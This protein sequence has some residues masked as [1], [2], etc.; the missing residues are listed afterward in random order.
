MMSKHVSILFFAVLLLL[1]WI[2]PSARAVELKVAV[3]NME[4][5][6]DEYNKTKE[7]NAQFKSRA[8]EMDIKRKELLADVKARKAEL[9][10]ISAEARDKSLS[11][12]ERAKK[13]TQ[14]EEKYAQGRE[15]EEKLVEFD[16]ACKLQFGE[17]MRQIQ[18]Q[19]VV[20]IRAIIQAY[21]KDR[22]FTLVLDSSGKTMNN[23][24]SVLTCDPSFDI[25]DA[26]L[27]VLNKQPP[28]AAASPATPTNSVTPPKK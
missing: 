7:A 10:A 14:E 18:K 23:V 20:E 28:K 12:A 5:L 2:Q 21:I 17:Q 8:D 4:R 16:K 26:I 19:I 15:A 11:D 6:F 27:T 1:P 24:E 13:K 9:D 22:G 3:V 25:T